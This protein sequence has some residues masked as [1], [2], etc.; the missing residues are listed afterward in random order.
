MLSSGKDYLQATISGGY[1]L[2]YLLWGLFRWRKIKVPP[3]MV[4]IYSI[5]ECTVILVEYY[6]P[7][8]LNSMFANDDLIV[9]DY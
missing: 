2:A 4:Y 3:E 1:I 5:V 8:A 9:G 7:E 6:Y